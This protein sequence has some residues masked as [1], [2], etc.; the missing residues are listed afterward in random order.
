MDLQ[1]YHRKV[2]LATYFKDCVKNKSKPFMPKSLWN[3]PPNQIPI[4]IH[5]LIK[6]NLIFFK[7]HYKIHQEKPNLTREEVKALRELSHNKLIVIKPANKGSAVVILSR[8]QYTTEVLRQLN[9]KKYYKK[10]DA[11]IY[12]Q[13]T[14]STK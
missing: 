3:P 11:P 14:S 12:P 4:E 5:E 10:L 7:K 2:K 13:T 8:E 9:D 1:N 6:N